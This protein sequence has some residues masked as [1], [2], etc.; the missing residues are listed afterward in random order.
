MSTPI[1]TRVSI[2]EAPWRAFMEAA[3]WK[4][5][6]HQSTT[7]RREHELHPGAVV[8]VDAGHH[9]Q[10]DDRHGEHGGDEGAPLEGVLG[11]DLVVEVVLVVSPGCR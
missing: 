7:G 4:G 9:R 1:E 11:G 6:A 2:V 5:Q 8:E 10:H 3:R